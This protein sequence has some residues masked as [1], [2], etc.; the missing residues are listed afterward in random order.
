MQFAVYCLGP[1]Q[2]I[3]VKKFKWLY[4]SEESFDTLKQEF[5]QIVQGKNERVQTFVLHLERGPK[6]D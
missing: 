4:W 6:G 1:L 3:S 2:M 5:Y